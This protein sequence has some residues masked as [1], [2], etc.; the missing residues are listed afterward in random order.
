MRDLTP[1][2]FAVIKYCPDPVRDE[3]VNVGVIGYIDGRLEMRTT[4][5]FS[6]IR[7][8]TGANDT[9][10]LQIALRFL[11]SEIDRTPKMEIQDLVYN[12]WGIIRFSEPIGGLADDPRE[13]LEEQYQIYVYDSAPTKASGMEDRAAI[14]ARVRKAIAAKGRRPEEFAIWKQRVRGKTGKHEFDYGFENGR[15]TLVRAISLQTSERY[16][17]TDA[18]TL[19]FAVLDTREALDDL[20]VTAIIAPPDQGDDMERREALGLI[21]SHVDRI[22][23][24]DHEDADLAIEDVF[25]SGIASVKPFSSNLLAEALR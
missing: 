16:A 17:L 18:R 19:S 23:M 25:R 10:S 8:T 14:R 3:T 7:S 4:P 12:S 5:R 22:V 21:Q 15:H 24:L 20:H 9:Q 1:V 6:R 2:P 13:F 11:Q